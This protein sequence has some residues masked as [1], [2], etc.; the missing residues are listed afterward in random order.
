MLKRVAVIGGGP[1]GCSAALRC[2]RL[3][4]SVVLFEARNHYRDKPCGDALLA[5]AVAHIHAFGLTDSDFRR[6]GGQPF[7]GIDL[8]LAQHCPAT[9]RQLHSSG[10]VIPRASLDQAL[11]DSISQTCEVRYN[12]VVR[13]LSLTGTG[14]AITVSQSPNRVEEFGAAILAT[15]VSTRLSRTLNINGNPDR[16]FA[17]RGYVSD[18]RDSDTLLFKVTNVDPIQYSWAF[19]LNDK[20]NIGVCRMDRSTEAVKA[21]LDVFAGSCRIT[22]LSGGVEPLW[23]GRASKWHHPRG[24]VSCGDSAGLVDPITG[25]G[26][27]AA[28]MSGEMAARAV[29]GYLG[30]LGVISLVNYS[31]QIRDVFATRYDATRRMNVL[32][33]HSSSSLD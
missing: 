1:A 6:L 19:P 22:K 10:W 23:S 33:P 7:E 18:Q 3:G 29:A 26:I 5:D 31:S 21:E 9:L 24:V 16:G 12:T 4:L 14:I 20:L 2:S 17:F 30:S 8:V 27:T 13:S 28:L 25:E 32:R 11:R 15:G